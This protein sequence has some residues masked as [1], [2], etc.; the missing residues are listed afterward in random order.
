MKN[1]DA[2]KL[3]N[4]KEFS[5][6]L[7]GFADGKGKLPASATGYIDPHLELSDTEAAFIDGVLFCLGCVGDRYDTLYG[8]IVRAVGGG[9]HIL[10]Q[11]AKQNGSEFDIAHL[12]NYFRNL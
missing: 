5:E 2:V 3:F 7:K 12:T 11:R 10:M 1:N 6:H 4:S 9:E 8:E